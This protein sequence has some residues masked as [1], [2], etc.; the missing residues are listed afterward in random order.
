MTNKK[1]KNSL[2]LIVSCLFLVGFGRTVSSLNK[3]G[4]KLYKEKKYEAALKKY[5]EAQVR[6][7]ENMILDYNM[8]CAFYKQD[9]LQSAAKSFLKIISSLED[10]STKEKAYYNLGNTLFRSG[11]LKGAIE[12]YKSALRLNPEDMDAK[13]NLEFAKKLLEQANKSPDTSKSGQQ[14]KKEQNQKH[15]Q[16]KQKGK[17]SKEEAKNLLKATEEEEKK[18]KEKTQKGKRQKVGI[19]R[20][21]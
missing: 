19:L 4:N 7:P 3:S 17:F 11:D 15:K 16:E 18:A 14:K 21:W 12:A 1:L 13:I 10:K 9:S 2:W 6:A 20:D 5:K 8:G